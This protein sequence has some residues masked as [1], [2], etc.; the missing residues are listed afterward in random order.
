MSY[1]KNYNGWRVSQLQIRDSLIENIGEADISRFLKK[2]GIEKKDL[3]Q[4]FKYFV[5]N[6]VG[7]GVSEEEFEEFCY[8]NLMY[9]KRKLIRVFEIANKRK[10]TDDDLWLN[11]LKQDFLVDS[12]NMSK[13]L[14]TNV[15]SI[16]NWKVV[17]VKTIDDER[18]EIG[19]ISILFECYIKVT[20]KICK[21]QDWCA[22]IP[23]EVDLKN[24]LLLVK[25]W[26]R[27]NV[28][29]EDEY[30]NHTLM[31]KIVVWL[32]EKIGI[33]VKFIQI[34]Y[35]KILANMNESLIQELLNAIPACSEVDL[36][37][38]FF[39]NVETKV[40]DQ[41]SFENV[42]EKDGK[43]VFNGRIIDIS[44]EMKNMIIR[45][46][47][48][49]YFFNRS[50]CEV[51]KMNLSAVINSVK[52][53]DLD[54]SITIVKSENNNK[55]VIC[56]KPF[57]MLLTAMEDSDSVDTISI[58]FRYRNRKFRISY[59][60]TKEEYIEIGILD[61]EDY[62]LA[63]FEEIWGILKKYEHGKNKSAQGDCKAAIG[64]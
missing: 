47:V 58:S 43:K 40:M 56:A 59:D 35:K 55:P 31:N 4:S 38:D 51:D 57:L 37:K 25:A 63:D 10:L 5:S 15:S 13:I 24:G 16:D 14:R 23:V 3:G 12:L 44:Q 33:K 64:E 41:I 60:A 48:S 27:Q 30:K 11:A 17:A 22:Y 39:Q 52:F 7:T 46:V 8:N 6:E 29:N 54:D 20:K 28:E 62:Y 53:S 2:R 19:T 45:A 21:D 50:L 36:M 26:R 49:D 32:K 61:P 42:I 1:N 18:G 34:D 9:G